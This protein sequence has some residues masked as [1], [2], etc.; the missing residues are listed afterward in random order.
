V[1]RCE[2]MYLYIDKTNVPT[3]GRQALSKKNQNKEN[4]NLYLSC[5]QFIKDIAIVACLKYNNNEMKFRFSESL[6][7]RELKQLKPQ[8]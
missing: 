4:L 7:S 1:G 2:F 5:I 8:H 3:W 6:E